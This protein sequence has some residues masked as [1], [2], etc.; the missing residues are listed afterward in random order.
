MR[1]RT[2]THMRGSLCV[3]VC[4]CVCVFVCLC[5]WMR[6]CPLSCRRHDRCG[7]APPRP[8][9]R[10]D[11]RRAPSTCARARSPAGPAHLRGNSRL[12]HI[13]PP[14]TPPAPTCRPR[15]VSHGDVVR[16]VHAVLRGTAAGTNSGTKLT[17]FKGANNGTSG[18][19]RETSCTSNAT[20]GTNNEALARWPVRTTRPLRPLRGSRVG[21]LADS[22]V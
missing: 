10:A 11:G 12:A 9:R 2:H 16:G 7:S 17:N 5:V 20:G 1:A 13:C 3:C 15:Q 14:L 19:K 4:V 8:R 21:L 18:T 22:A 6:A